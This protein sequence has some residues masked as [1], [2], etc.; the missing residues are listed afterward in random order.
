MKDR[1]PITTR[2][3]AEEYLYAKY[4]LLKRY[5]GWNLEEFDLAPPVEQIVLDLQN[6]MGNSD[7]FQ[8]LGLL[9]ADGTARDA[10]WHLIQGNDLRRLCKN[11]GDG[12]FRFARTE[13]DKRH[14]WN[15][16]FEG[17]YK[18]RHLFVQYS[19]TRDRLGNAGSQELEVQLMVAQKFWLR[20]RE[21]KKVSDPS[22]VIVRRKQG[23]R[24]YTMHSNDN[25]AALH[26]LNDPVVRKPLEILPLLFDKLEI[27]RGW[28]R[29]LFRSFH[30]LN[31]TSQEVVATLEGFA[32]ILP[33][34]ET[35]AGGFKMNVSNSSSECPFC[36]EDLNPTELL[37]TCP[38]CKT[39]MHDACWR[40]NGQCTTWGCHRAAAPKKK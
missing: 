4:P 17:K 19:Y 20:L 1:L 12:I 31:M 28:L 2:K 37:W 34:Y 13:R 11:L 10:I 5:T 22:S 36:K 33:F 14:R 40:Q 3:A 38:R 23:N 15:H 25:A 35:W 8:L 21:T 18:K 39:S 30:F 29:I 7:D 32:G 24:S 6:H 9:Y 27:Y 16:F 26:F